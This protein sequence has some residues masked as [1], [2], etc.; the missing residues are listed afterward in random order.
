MCLR[1]S[2]LGRLGWS[3][4]ETRLIGV[5]QYISVNAITTTMCEAAELASGTTFV[6]VLMG[7]PPDDPADLARHGGPP[8]LDPR[9]L[10]LW[11]R[12]RADALACRR[13]PAAGSGA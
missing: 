8:A 9:L 12:G 6:C 5:T 11:P 4:L 10:D 13:L 3:P 2:D 1:A 7:R